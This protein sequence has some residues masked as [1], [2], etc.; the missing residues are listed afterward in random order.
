MTLQKRK[1]KT[2][3]TA[4]AHEIVSIDLQKQN[5]PEVMNFALAAVGRNAWHSKPVLATNS[6]RILG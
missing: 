4:G 5:I 3:A 2:T 6:E 1:K